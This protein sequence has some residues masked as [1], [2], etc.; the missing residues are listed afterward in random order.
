ME[1]LLDWLPS[2]DISDIALNLLE[3]VGEH[4]HYS[5]RRL[6][7]YRII[8]ILIFTFLSVFV[9]AP[10]FLSETKKYVETMEALV[11]V[12]HVSTILIISI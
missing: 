6:T 3:L 8:N 1:K 4:M 2:N 12:L 10:L 7:V 11:T 5:S 9:I